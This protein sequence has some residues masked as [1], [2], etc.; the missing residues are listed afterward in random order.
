MKFKA[1]AASLFAA[2]G[3]SLATPA[4]ATTVV[5]D[6]N[7]GQ[8][9]SFVW[10]NGLG[11]IDEIDGVTDFDNMHFSVFANAGDTIDAGLFDCCVAG[12]E[13]Q[14]L[15]N[16]SVV[17]PTS[18]TPG[19]FTYTYT[20]IVLAAGVNIFDINVTALAPGF[21]SGGAS[22]SFSALTGGA[23]PEPSAWALMIL[24]FGAV[25]ASLRRSRQRT[26]IAYA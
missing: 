18:V 16:G 3:A 21:E 19:L 5:I 1:F 8:S 14:L 24:G 9:G 6:P 26:S 25:G 7:T 10:Y 2:A 12:D 20:G 23:V 11:A 22:Y 17:T 15:L 13:F 4:A